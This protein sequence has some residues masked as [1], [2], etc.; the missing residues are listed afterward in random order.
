MRIAIPTTLSDL[1]RNLLLKLNFDLSTIRSKYDGLWRTLE[2]ME[3]EFIKIYVGHSGLTTTC[4]ITCKGL[5]VIRTIEYDSFYP[6]NRKLEFY[7]DEEKIN[8]S[9]QLCEQASKE[10]KKT[11]TPT[12]FQTKLIERIEQLKHI[13]YG[14][15]AERGWGEVIPRNLAYLKGYKEENIA[16]F[17]QVIDSNKVYQDMYYNLFPGWNDEKNLTPTYIKKDRGIFGAISTM[18]YNK[19]KD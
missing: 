1:E 4:T 11:F 3:T 17:Y 9:L 14:G 10:E 13:I 19:Q 2:V 15:G 16:E 7:I 8:E 6:E 18:I 5:Q 12:E